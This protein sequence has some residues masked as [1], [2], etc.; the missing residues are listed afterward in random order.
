MIP[1]SNLKLPGQLISKKTNCQERIVGFKKI[2]L[3]V[4]NSE[5][6]TPPFQADLDA[7]KVNEMIISY[8]K[9][10]EYLLFKNKIVVGVIPPKITEDQNNYSMFIIDGQHR[11]EMAIKL[12][13]EGVSDDLCICYYNTPNNKEMKK[14]F[15]EINKDSIRN[16]K[17]ISLNEFNQTTRDELKDYFTKE[18]N[19]AF[20]QKKSKSNRL[21]TINEFLDKLDERK[22]M[23][24]LSSKKIIKQIVDKN[25]IFY[26][27]IDY[28]EY[29]ND[30]PNSI[31]K[32]ELIPIKNGYIYGLINNNFI[33]YLLDNENK[34]IPEHNFKKIKDRISPTLRK[35][36]WDL[37]YKKETGF[38]PLCNILINNGKDGFHCGHIISEANGGK[39]TIDNLRPICASC[40]LKMGSNN[41]DDYV[42]KINKKDTINIVNKS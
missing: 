33:D 30:D 23:E 4:K 42:K 26:K 13:E 22:Y 11:I 5:L 29:C 32:E 8:K 10:K 34:I 20:S 18:R 6:Q 31:Y 37:I 39:I 35:N 3:L 25:D 40:N 9:N 12:S 7:D 27:Y 2:A 19:L 28:N 21:Y 16:L 15:S 14:L 17:Y 38:C 24:N 41:W 1:F 36:V